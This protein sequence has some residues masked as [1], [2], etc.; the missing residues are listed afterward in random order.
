MFM[1]EE[2]DSPGKTWVK[3]LL[4]AGI[5]VLVV[6][7]V[8]ADRRTVDFA[9]V[10]TGAES[11]VCTYIKK[12]PRAARAL[13]P[14]GRT[15]LQIVVSRQGDAEALAAV[16]K[17][18]AEAGADLDVR[19]AEEG[20]KTPLMLAVHQGRLPVL[21]ALLESGADVNLMDG[22]GRTVLD[23]ARR[24]SNPA[25]IALIEAVYAAGY[26][27]EQG[28]VYAVLGQGS[29]AEV[30]KLLSRFANPGSSTF[31]MA[32]VA[33]NADPEVVKILLREGASVNAVDAVGMTPLA[34]AVK[35]NGNP[36]VAAMLIKAGVRVNGLL[37]DGSTPLCR[38]AA[39]SPVEVV[40]ALLQ[41][42]ADPNARDRDGKLPL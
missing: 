17:A 27:P 28:A 32:A 42:G 4:I 31:L 37:D 10:T 1:P 15:V 6:V 3:R 33:H 24:M 20:D 14:D 41:A 35:F 2:S 22:E 38:A 13:A 11:E 18:L 36:A 39:E 25:V 21:R 29:P 7:K 16:I 40:K 8:A 30:R 12:H 34:Y 23:Q 9:L 26:A 5:V 19:T